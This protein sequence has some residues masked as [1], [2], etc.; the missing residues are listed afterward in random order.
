MKVAEVARVVGAEDGVAEDGEE[1]DLMVFESPA[2]AK[3][4]RTS[5]QRA[6]IILALLTLLN[7]FL[8]AVRWALW[9]SLRV[10]TLVAPERA[11]PC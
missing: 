8:A 2:H 4:V 1:E 9:A 6:R 11:E 5:R 3:R 10:L 7:S